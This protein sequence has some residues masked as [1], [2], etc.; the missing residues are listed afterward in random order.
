VQTK[1]GSF[2]TAI[3]QLVRLTSGVLLSAPSRG[4]NQEVKF[5]MA[6]KCERLHTALASWKDP[7]GYQVGFDGLAERFGGWLEMMRGLFF[8]KKII[9]S[10]SGVW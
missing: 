7:G 3:F 8:K 4:R 10:T 1:F 2:R 6:L 9:I 5:A